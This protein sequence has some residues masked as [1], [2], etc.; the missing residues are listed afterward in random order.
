MAEQLCVDTWSFIVVVG[1]LLI[2]ASLLSALFRLE[3]WH[4]RRQLRRR[5]VEEGMRSGNSKSPK[6]RKS[7]GTT[8]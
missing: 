7:L 8:K 3:D 1:G 4:H 2:V 6:I 5:E